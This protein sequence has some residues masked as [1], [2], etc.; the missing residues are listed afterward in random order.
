M[1]YYSF[2]ISEN[3]YVVGLQLRIRVFDGVA[4]FFELKTRQEMTRILNT[5]DVNCIFQAFFLRI[6]SNGGGSTWGKIK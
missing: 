4:W 2:E 1:A 6:D 3:S 5:L